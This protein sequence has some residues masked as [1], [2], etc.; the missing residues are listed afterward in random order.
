V[1][2]G[3]IIWLDCWY[4]LSEPKAEQAQ[5]RKGVKERAETNHKLMRTGLYS[6]NTGHFFGTGLR[7]LGW[8]A[9]AFALFTIV[10]GSVAEFYGYVAAWL[11][12]PAGIIA[13][14]MYYCTEFDLEHKTYREGVRLAGITFGNKLPLPGFEFLFLKRNRYKQVSESKLSRK[15]FRMEKFDGYLK[16]SDGVKLHLVQTRDKETAMQEMEQIARDLQVELLDLT[17]A[18]FF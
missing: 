4:W 9:T 8:I 6:Y 14:F 12:L 3:S 16:L 13:Q 11:L 5:T 2:R 17:D 18:K 10:Y 15:T 7:V 1:H